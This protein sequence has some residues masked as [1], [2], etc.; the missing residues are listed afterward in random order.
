MDF[1]STAQIAQAGVEYVPSKDGTRWAVRIAGRSG[2]RTPLVMLHGLR[3]HSGWFVQSQTFLAGL[4]IPVYGQNTEYA[5]KRKSQRLDPPVL[6]AVR[7]GEF[8]EY[9]ERKVSDAIIVTPR[10][11]VVRRMR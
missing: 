11:K 7:R 3:S 5:S 10:G 6:R 9:R 4:G 8:D 2:S 1:L